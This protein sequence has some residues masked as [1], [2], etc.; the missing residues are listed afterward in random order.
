MAQ[1]SNHPWLSPSGER[2]EI[3][4]SLTLLAMIPRSA[5]PSACWLPLACGIA[6]GCGPLGVRINTTG[7]DAGATKAQCRAQ[8]DLPEDLHSTLDTPLAIL[9]FLPEGVRGNPAFYIKSGFRPILSFSSPLP[10]N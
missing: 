1:L 3:A 7:R 5:G 6:E 9:E 8:P 2:I 10:G 4:T